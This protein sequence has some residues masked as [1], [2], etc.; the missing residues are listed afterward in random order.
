MFR[1]CIYLLWLR[2]SSV[3]LSWSAEC[4]L[5]KQLKHSFDTK[6]VDAT[7][8][9]KIATFGVHNVV[10]VEIQHHCISARHLRRYEV[11]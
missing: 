3:C 1:Q 6:Q 9:S 11:I 5:T 4:L 10:R 7:T 8:G 2:N